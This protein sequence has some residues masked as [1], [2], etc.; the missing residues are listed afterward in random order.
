V[1]VAAGSPVD[2]ATRRWLISPQ[3]LLAAC[4]EAALARD[5]DFLEEL[6]TSPLLGVLDDECLQ[7]PG[8]PPSERTLALVC[9]GRLALWCLQGGDRP[10]VIQS[11]LAV[12]VR[13]FSGPSDPQWA[14]RAGDIDMVEP[15]TADPQAA[16]TA[17]MAGAYGS[18]ARTTLLAVGDL[19]RAF[20]PALHGPDV[21]THIR[22]P[23]L[24][25]RHH[26]GE[27]VHL[28]VLTRPGP[29]GIAL[30]P[31]VCP[32]TRADAAFHQAVATA[33]QANHSPSLST[34]W[35]VIS[36]RTGVA[37]EVIGG[38]SVGAAAGTA[39]RYLTN[40]GLS[41]LDA[42]WAVT[43]ALDASGS[44]VSLLDEEHN[45]A[46]YR[47]KLLAAGAR[48][49]VMPTCDHP[50]V[51]GLLESGDLKARLVPAASLVEITD[52]ARRDAAANVAHDA[53]WER[54]PRLRRASVVQ[55]IVASVL[56]GILA[57]LGWIG[58]LGLAAGAVIGTATVAFGWLVVRRPGRRGRPRVWTAS[59]TT[60]VVVAT[61]AYS[62]FG[63]PDHTRPT[64]TTQ[65]HDL[66]PGSDPGTLVADKHGNLWFTEASQHRIGRISVDGFRNEFAVPRLPGAASGDPPSP[67][68]LAK[69][70]DG[71]IWFT[72]GTDVI[73][74]VTP[75][76]RF[77]ERTISGIDRGGLVAGPDGNMWV[78]EDVAQ[79]ARISP[80]GVITEFPLPVGEAN[81][82]ASF[83]TRAGMAVGRDGNVWFTEARG[84]IARITP[85]G[86]VT[87][88]FL[89]TP[90]T[91][92]GG[93]IAGPDGNLW[94]IEAG[95]AFKIGRITPSGTV[96]EF[97]LL[98]LSYPQALTV[99]SDGGIWFTEVVAA[100][101]IKISGANRIGRLDP[102]HPDEFPS[103]LALPD[104]VDPAGIATGGD[105][106]LW[107]A[108]TKADQ[109][110]TMPAVAPSKI[111]SVSRGAGQGL[112]DAFQGFRAQIRPADTQLV[113]DRETHDLE[114]IKADYAREADIVGGL[115]TAV[116]R[117]PVPSAVGGEVNAVLRATTDLQAVLNGVRSIASEEELYGDPPVRVGVTFANADAV[118]KLVVA[119]NSL[120][121]RLG[122]GRSRGGPVA[123]DK[124]ASAVTPT[125]RASPAASVTSTLPGGPA[126]ISGEKF[127]PV[128]I[129]PAGKADPN[130]WPDACQMLTDAEI[131]ALVPGVAVS[132]TGRG[133][134]G[135][136]GPPEKNTSCEYA[137]SRPDYPPKVYDAIYVGLD[138]VAASTTAAGQVFGED[139]SR[140]AESKRLHPQ[141]YVDYGKSLGADDAFWDGSSIRCHTGPFWF[142]VSGQSQQLTS[143]GDME[144]R[145][146]VLTLVVRTLS[147][148]MT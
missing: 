45:L 16:A 98:G 92:P 94:F 19:V 126:L 63:L 86:A 146:K 104:D 2:E 135:P 11:W 9:A 70:A 30:D 148:K 109:I 29:P 48:T 141:D 41:P 57:V 27:L 114:A 96:T 100:G 8:P 120:G 123:A 71:N 49:V 18:C 97:D 99:G 88:F 139:K 39:L 103:Y 106:N 37:V 128:T 77:T 136:D 115:E 67:D 7:A 47:A 1:R 113:A 69:G 35:S 93:I 110:V 61:G 79:V 91:E 17:L 54:S 22:V 62:L 38:R 43:G 102:K 111:P 65:S 133:A 87:E 108:E 142:A 112:L 147:A 50:H 121:T 44:L 31:L 12:A 36:D 85:S 105:G 14:P 64:R 83:L 20:L 127:P 144:W 132:R 130:Q 68:F 89:P 125:S 74:S 72:A 34:R 32:F 59:V 134:S 75:S 124:K 137:L 84:R 129:D 78:T 101:G 46:T 4:R 52:A 42:S 24:T 5:V 56:V 40:P 25:S 82:R 145:D 118:E 26:H 33:W 143:N 81:F 6:A 15:P 122:T 13:G 10:P 107:F 119:L 140:A 60:V 73:G 55:A 53:V 66:P 117:L 80:S 51:A 3:G 116:R 28:Q 95:P 131:E 76:G 21:A 138:D 90:D 23:L 58:R